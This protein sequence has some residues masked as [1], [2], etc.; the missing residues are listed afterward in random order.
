MTLDVNS[1]SLSQGLSLLQ[2]QPIQFRGLLP[3]FYLQ[4]RLSFASYLRP[5]GRVYR[6]ILYASVC[7]VTTKMMET[8]CAQI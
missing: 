3:F 5:A 8:T 1:H 2:Y 4:D 7:T 6:N